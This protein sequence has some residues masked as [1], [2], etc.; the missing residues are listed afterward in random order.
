MDYKEQEIIAKAWFAMPPKEDQP[1]QK[2]P[3]GTWVKVSNEMPPC[4]SHFEKGFIGIVNYTYA[5]KYWGDDVKSYCLIMLDKDNKPINSIAWY[6]EDQ[7]TLVS[8][9]IDTGIQIIKAFKER[10]KDNR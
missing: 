4:M 3:R 2:F 10:N 5:Q 1:G 7:L 8:N 9:D 6:Y